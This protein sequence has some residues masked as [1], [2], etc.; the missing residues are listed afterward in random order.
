MATRKNTNFNSH[1]YTV[2]H[3]L[4]MININLVCCLIVGLRCPPS[5][6]IKRPVFRLTKQQSQQWQL[7]TLYG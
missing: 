5:P 2:K 3:Y 4:F 1:M 6:E 7:P